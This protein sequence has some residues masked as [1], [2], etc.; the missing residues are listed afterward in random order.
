MTIDAQA[1]RHHAADVSDAS[2]L[3]VRGRLDALTPDERCAVEETAHAVGRS[4]ADCLL[5]RAS[6]DEGLAAVLSALYP[7]GGNGFVPG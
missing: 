5:E 1:L 2:L 6:S 3:R 7:P 4:V